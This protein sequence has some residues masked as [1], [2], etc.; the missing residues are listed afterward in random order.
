M[1]VV[2]VDYGVGNLG[3]IVN[4]FRKSGID[5]AVTSDHATIRSASRLVL[6]GV[7]AFDHGMKHLVA[8]GLHRVLE[9]C[10]V[11]HG[12]PIL[13]ICLG[14]QLLT[15]RSEEG[16]ESGLGWIP[17]SVVRFDVSRF[18]TRLAIPHM[19]W[20]YV[21]TSPATTTAA[22]TASPALLDGSR[23]YFVHAYHAQCDD[24]TNVWGRTTYG[25]E[26][27]SAIRSG[28]IFGVQFHPEKSHR[29]GCDLLRSFAEYPR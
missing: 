1:S 15:T 27:A 11:A 10:V 12:T 6:P 24:D 23:F 2:I 13:G 9:A 28:H 14:M 26:F 3:S 8:S 21:T 20:N 7:G 18:P 25:Y 19:G 16:V 4:M 29:F 22:T 5:A 17:A